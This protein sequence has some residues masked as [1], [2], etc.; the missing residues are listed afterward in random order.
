MYTTGVLGSQAQVNYR[1]SYWFD[2]LKFRGEFVTK[3]LICGFPRT[4]IIGSIPD[5]S[6]ATKLLSVSTLCDSYFYII[7]CIFILL[8]SLI[9][10]LVFRCCLRIKQRCKP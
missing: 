6:M 3:L 10:I 4:F 5:E 8:L 7:F 2:I 1:S 9:S